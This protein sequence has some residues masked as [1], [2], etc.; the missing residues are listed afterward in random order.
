M[1]FVILTPCKPNKPRISTRVDTLSL[2]FWTGVQNPPSPLVK[3][4]APKGAFVFWVE[5]S[6][7]IV[8][9]MWGF[10]R[11]QRCFV[12]RRN[13]EGRAA[14]FFCDGKRKLVAE[15]PISTIRPPNSERVG[16]FA[17]VRDG[18]FWKTEAVY[19]GAFWSDVVAESGWAQAMGTH[20]YGS[21]SARPFEVFSEK[22]KRCTAPVRRRTLRFLVRLCAKRLSDL[23]P[24]PH[25][26]NYKNELTLCEPFLFVEMSKWTA[27]L[28]WGYR[29]AESC[30]S[31]D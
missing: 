28:A 5:M 14:S 15:T 9:P 3:T 27:S 31:S 11:P 10:W 6:G 24:K 25:L 16:W 12:S 18:G 26:H 13:R 1:G 19:D 8:L 29:K 30:F 2:L 7:Q 20:S 21:L 4:L 17:F 23:W 22:S